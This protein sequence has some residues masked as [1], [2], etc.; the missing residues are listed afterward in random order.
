MGTWEVSVPNQLGLSRWVWEIRP[1]GTYKFHAEGP[2]AVPGHGGTFAA[3]KGHYSL[4]STTLAWNHT[5][6]HQVV[7]K[8]TLVATGRLGTGTWQKV[9]S[10][11]SGEGRASH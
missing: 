9:Q 11:V 6:T 4:N 1:D 8:T 7:S 10:K 2:G 3:A 5:G